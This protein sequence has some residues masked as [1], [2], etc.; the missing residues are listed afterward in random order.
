M[1]NGTNKWL[2]EELMLPTVASIECLLVES[3]NVELADSRS[4]Y[5]K[6]RSCNEGVMESQV[7]LWI[8]GSTMASILFI[9]F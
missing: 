7:G 2:L 6:R 3:V 4:K 1:L 5:N 9:M 8:Y